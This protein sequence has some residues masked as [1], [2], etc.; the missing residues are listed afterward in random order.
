M[1]YYMQSAISGQCLAM[2]F[3]APLIHTVQIALIDWVVHLFATTAH[4][5]T[6]VNSWILIFAV[7]Q[8]AV[9]FVIF[10]CYLLLDSVVAFLCNMVPIQIHKFGIWCCCY[11][12]QWLILFEQNCNSWILLLIFK[13]C[14]SWYVLLLY[15]AT[16]ELL[17]QG[18]TLGL[19][20]FKRNAVQIFQKFHKSNKYI[21]KFGYSSCVQGCLHFLLCARLPAF[22]AMLLQLVN[23]H[24]V[25]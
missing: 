11:I 17:C 18:L 13:C 5:A 15:S 16:V 21:H 9:Q 23:F 8:T 19:S 7:V 22:V 24:F 6:A 14:I 25:V 4:F 2:L 1:L 20:I 3:V 12:F 10:V